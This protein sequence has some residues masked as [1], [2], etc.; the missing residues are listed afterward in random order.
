[1]LIKWPSSPSSAALVPKGVLDTKA[2]RRLPPKAHQNGRKI[3]ESTKTRKPV[4]QSIIQFLLG[5]F[6]TILHCPKGEHHSIRYIP[7]VLRFQPFFVDL[8]FS[9]HFPH[10]FPHI[11][12]RQP[13]T[14]SHKLVA[15]LLRH[16]LVPWL[17]G[18][19]HE[20][21]C[22]HNSSGQSV[23]GEKCTSHVIYPG[24][25]AL[26]SVT[27]TTFG[28]SCQTANWKHVKTWRV[29]IVTS[30][31]CFPFRQKNNSYAQHGWSSWNA[32]EKGF[33]K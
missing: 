23:E 20:A 25:K 30:G 17:Q 18:E 9:I 15:V 31:P 1:M 12:A 29:G 22:Q 7:R 11:S 28:S 6:C 27:T 26:P 32:K 13:P 10:I 4:L 21:S 24:I 3:I 2:P 19:S 14:P 8:F 33:D 16:P 5:C